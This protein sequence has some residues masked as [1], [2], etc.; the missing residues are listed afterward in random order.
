[1]I[2]IAGYCHSVNTHS[3][4][5][6]TLGLHFTGW[7]FIHI[8]SYGQKGRTSKKMPDLNT[9]FSTLALFSRR[10][11]QTMDNARKSFNVLPLSKYIGLQKSFIAYYHTEFIFQKYTISTRQIT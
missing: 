7:H 3:S 11:R 8:T 1:M 2:P 6:V 5:I 9:I 10:V 4:I